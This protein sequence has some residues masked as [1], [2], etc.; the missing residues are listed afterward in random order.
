VTPLECFLEIAGHVAV[1]SVFDEES[2]PV[3]GALPKLVRAGRALNRQLSLAAPAIARTQAGMGQ[4]KL[5]I[6]LDRALEQRDAGAT[7]GSARITVRF[8]RFE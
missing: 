1:V 6:E 5:G 2:F 4:R 3:S 7:G 8:Q